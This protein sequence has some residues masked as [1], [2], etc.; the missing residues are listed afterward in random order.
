MKPI[1]QTT[2]LLGAGFALSLSPFANAQGPLAPPGAPAPLFKTLDQVEPRRPIE[3]L[4]FT[5]NQPGSYYLTG[6][7][8]GAGGNGITIIANNVTLDLMGFALVG[9]P[10]TTDGVN[11]SVNVTNIT[12]RNGSI[13]RWG[14]MGVDADTAF[15]SQISDVR[16]SHKEVGSSVVA[17]RRAMA[18]RA[19]AVKTARRSV[20]V[21]RAPT[22]MA[23]SSAQ[24]RP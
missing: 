16:S 5:I 20:D 17:R 13:S 18:P 22:T 3:S 1:V 19:S 11:V 12:I 8:N 7:L 21:R 23:F 24:D 10:G 2:L 9:G 14:G 15:N 6:N 4:P